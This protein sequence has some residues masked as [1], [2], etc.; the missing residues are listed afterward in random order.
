M[1][2]K[3]CRKVWDCA[4]PQNFHT[5]KLGEISVFYAVIQ[6]QSLSGKINEMNIWKIHFDCLKA[7]LDLSQFF[8]KGLI[9]KEKN[10]RLAWMLLH[11]ILNRFFKLDWTKKISFKAI[12]NLR[13]LQYTKL[14]ENPV[15]LWPPFFKVTLMQIW[16]SSYMF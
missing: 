13:L 14:A 9:V 8:G 4:F 11:Y 3:I 16:K 2:Y 7:T 5:T 15:L 12:Q 6:T 1:V 10:V